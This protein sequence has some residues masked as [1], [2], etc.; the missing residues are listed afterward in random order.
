MA[1]VVENNRIHCQIYGLT[2]GYCSLDQELYVVHFSKLNLN[3]KW[4]FFRLL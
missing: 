4:V 1:I 2:I 3:Y